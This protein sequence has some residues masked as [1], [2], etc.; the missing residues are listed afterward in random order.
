MQRWEAVCSA[1]AP[2]AREARALV[3]AAIARTFFHQQERRQLEAE[4]VADRKRLMVSQQESAEQ[5]IAKAVAAEEKTAQAKREFHEGV[6]EFA[7][8]DPAFKKARPAQQKVRPDRLQSTARVTVTW[9]RQHRLALAST[10]LSP[11]LRAPSRNRNC[12]RRRW[13]GRWRSSPSSCS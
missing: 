6:A 3:R 2:T 7:K 5:D 10:R 9:M 8:A 13:R 11:S 1:D 12:S 4:T